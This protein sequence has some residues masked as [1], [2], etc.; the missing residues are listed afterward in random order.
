MQKPVSEEVLMSVRRGEG[1]T[2]PG[3]PLRQNFYTTMNQDR[4]DADI[5]FN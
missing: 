1:F 5:H 4:G 2:T 3:E